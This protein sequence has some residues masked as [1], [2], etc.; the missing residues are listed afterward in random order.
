MGPTGEVF[1]ERDMRRLLAA[2]QGRYAVRVRD[3]SGR[4]GVGSAGHRHRDDLERW[5][6]AVDGFARAVLG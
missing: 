2:G 5:V 4:V 1:T 3:G 6:E